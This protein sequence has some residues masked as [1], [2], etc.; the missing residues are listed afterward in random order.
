MNLEEIKLDIQSFADDDADVIVENNGNILFSRN[1]KD[2]IIDIYQDL[3]TGQ[4]LVNYEGERMV[5]RQFI[6]KKL[7]NLDLFATKIVEKRMPPDPYIDGN[8]VLFSATNSQ[9]KKGLELIHEECSKFLLSGT[10]LT[11]ITADAGHGKTALLKQYQSEQ[12]NRYLRGE[13]SFLF[14]HVDLQG[15]ELVRL[16]E[17]IMYDL[18]EL[19]IPGL[20]YSSIL[21]LLKRKFIVLS[22]DG[23]D[24]LAAEVGGSIALGALSSL[25]L[26]MKNSGTIIA[27]SRRTFFDTQNYIKRTKILR[28]KISSECQ[29][30]EMKLQNWSKDNAIDFISYYDDDPQKIYQELLIELNSNSSHPIITRPFLL[31]KVIQGMAELEVSPAEFIGQLSDPLEGVAAVVEAFTKREVSKWKLRD[32]DTGKP[33]LSYEQHVTLLSQIAYDMWESKSDKIS[34]EEIQLITTLLCDDWVIE[35][36]VRPRIISMVNSHALLIPPNNSQADLRKFEHEEFKNYFLSRYLVTIINSFPSSNRSIKR[37]LKKI[38]YIAQLP[39]SVAKYTSKYINVDNINMPALLDMFAS[40]IEEEWKPT[41]LQTNIGTFIPY[42]L[43]D[44][45]PKTIIEFSAKVNYIS[46]IYENKNLSRIRILN[47]NFINIS[48]RNTKFENVVFDNCTFN[49]IRVHC[50][51]ENN[52]RGT[53]LVDCDIAC[54]ILYKDNNIINSAYSPLSISVTLKD[55]G[56]E[57]NKEEILPSIKVRNPSF[58]KVVNR[59]LNVYNKSTLFYEMNIKEDGFY[60]KDRGLILNDIIPLLLKYR[61][62]E[63]RTTKSTKKVNS[64]AWSLTIDLKELFSADA[65]NNNLECDRDNENIVCFWE[66]VNS[67]E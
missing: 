59:F 4:F 16:N 18:G 64:K 31:T 37:Q 56:F 43:H 5:Y 20:Y 38:L 62:L 28:G 11:F 63:E 1:G 35:L 7:A 44:Y 29:F 32:S 15:R 53:R 65:E 22:I 13:S 30:N 41:Y 25:V 55:L 39:D 40:I 19:R 48:F 50:D 3:E 12:A 21:T 9:E 36:K 42:F 10:K 67:H 57:L 45:S 66:E 52:F 17:A 34:I 14:W 51:S 6:A 33:Y 58:K 8:A 61:I 54:V 2:I 46:L 60:S 24:E 23:F 26:Q 49:E 27:A 47:G